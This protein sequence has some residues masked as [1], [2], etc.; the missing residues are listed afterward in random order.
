MEKITQTEAIKKLL[1][2]WE[3]IPSSDILLMAMREIDLPLYGLERSTNN[4]TDI[5]NII[6]YVTAHGRLP[7]FI[8]AIIKAT[9]DSKS[10]SELQ[11][12]LVDIEQAET[13]SHIVLVESPNNSLAQTQQLTPKYLTENLAPYLNAIG[14]IQNIIDSIRERSLRNVIITAITQNSPISV[15]LDGAAETIQL[16]KE[17]VV[18]WRKA[19]AESMARLVEQEKQ[20]EIEVKKAE[21][22]EKRAHA[23]KDRVDAAKQREEAEK[24][25][26]ENEKLRLDLQRAKIQLALDILTQIA[27]ALQEKERIDYLVKLLPSLDIVIFNNLEVEK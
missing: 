15:S 22:L 27:P 2:Q 6:Q 13:S 5:F 18:P 9:P 1:T 3:V 19:H 14:N 20:T 10:K 25:K 21:V 17:S 4:R 11:K 12:I 23:E 26:L 7:E 24:I 8:E 16:I